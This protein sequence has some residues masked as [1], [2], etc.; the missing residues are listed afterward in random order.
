MPNSSSCR[1]NGLFS[2]AE[3]M[4]FLKICVVSVPEKG[5]ANK[6]L[7]NFLSKKIGIGKSQMEIVSGELDRY[8]KIKIIGDISAIVSKLQKLITEGQNDSSDY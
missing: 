4:Q 6:E 7:L 3:G 1:V 8:K 2:D 5:K